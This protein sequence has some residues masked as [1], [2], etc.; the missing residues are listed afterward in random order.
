V[1]DL[2]LFLLVE[3]LGFTPVCDLFLFLPLP[4]RFMLYQRLAE[5]ESKETDPSQDPYTGAME[6]LD[7]ALGLAAVVAIPAAVFAIISGEN[8]CSSGS[9][10][11]SD[12][13]S[14]SSSS[15]SSGSGGGGGGSSIV[16]VV[17]VVVDVVIVV[18]VVI[19]GGVVV[20][21]VVAAAAG[22]SPGLR[23]GSGRSG[24]DSG[25]RVCHHFW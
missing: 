17:V 15:S 6:A 16:V 2:F 9:G 13:S 22:V 5:N 10:G 20:D 3:P 23:A 11:G 7:Y 19:V 24:G 1:C 25:G 21:V 12:S 14:S 4:H 18:A 8:L